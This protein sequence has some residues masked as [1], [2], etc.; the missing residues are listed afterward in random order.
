MAIDVQNG[1]AIGM[2]AGWAAHPFRSDMSA[3]DWVL[4]LGL[5]LCA[6][7][8]WTRLLNHFLDD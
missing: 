3:I 7:W 5:I 4:F 1:G 8:M 2:A 6:A